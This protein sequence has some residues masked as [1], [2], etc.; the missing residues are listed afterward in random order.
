[1]E[2]EETFGNEREA[3]WENLRI[4][5]KFIDKPRRICYNNEV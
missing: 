5:L 1:M 2:D 3:F 4:I